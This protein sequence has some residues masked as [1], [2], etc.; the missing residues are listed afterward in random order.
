MQGIDLCT[1][2]GLR[3]R[4]TRRA[5]SYTHLD[6]YKRQTLICNRLFICSGFGGQAGTVFLQRKSHTDVHGTADTGGFR[7]FH[8]L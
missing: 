4:S 5:V 6:V 7:G 3:L 1:T 8:H 2:L